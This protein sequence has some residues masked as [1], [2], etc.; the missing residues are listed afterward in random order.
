MRACVCVCVCA[1]SSLKLTSFIFSKSCGIYDLFSQKCSWKSVIFPLL[2]ITE[3][4][5]LSR[6]SRQNV[7]CQRLLSS[8][9]KHMISC[10]LYY[11][12]KTFCK[13]VIWSIL[14]GFLSLLRWICICPP[15]WAPRFNQNLARPTSSCPPWVL[16]FG[17]W[18]LTSVLGAGILAA[19]NVSQHKSQVEICYVW[20]ITPKSRSSL[21]PEFQGLCPCLRHP[22]KAATLIS[23]CVTS[24]NSCILQNRAVCNSRGAGCNPLAGVKH[25]FCAKKTNEL[26]QNQTGGKCYMSGSQ[27]H[28]WCSKEADRS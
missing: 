16:W 11:N 13:A 21:P 3:R 12:C 19:E 6:C 22:C 28:K 24:I 17:R 18:Y 4:L 14:N 10:N 23:N 1:F 9:I 15:P 20:N 27:F 5:L 2:L 8:V 26:E 25:N 7:F